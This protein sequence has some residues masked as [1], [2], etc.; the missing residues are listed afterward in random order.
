MLPFHWVSVKRALMLLAGNEPHEILEVE[1]SA[2]PLVV[3]NA[4]DSF[5]RNSC[6]MEYQNGIL[7]CNPDV[8]TLI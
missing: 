3:P 8:T 2:K 6:G 1:G 7:M 4:P 5:G